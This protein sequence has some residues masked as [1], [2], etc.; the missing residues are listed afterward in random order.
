MTEVTQLTQT[1]VLV[2]TGLATIL[3]GV[4][5]WNQNRRLYK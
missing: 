3:L 2:L 4:Y 1:I 5:L